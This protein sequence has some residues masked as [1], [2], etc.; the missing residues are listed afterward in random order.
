MKAATSLNRSN[1]S[2]RAVPGRN[3]SRVVLSQKA[4]SNRIV[5]PAKAVPIARLVQGTKEVAAGNAAYRI[6]VQSSKATKVGPIGFGSVLGLAYYNAHVIGFT[7][8]GKILEIDPQTGK[9][10]Q[11]A[12]KGIQFWGASMSPLVTNNRCP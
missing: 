7:E 8:S 12:A 11:I 9:G 4:S 3:N 1:N 5:A 10:V 6:D 2:R